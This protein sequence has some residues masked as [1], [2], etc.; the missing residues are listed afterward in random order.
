MKFVISKAFLGLILVVIGI[1]LLL[2]SKG[3]IEG[4]EVFWI[5]ICGVGALLFLVAFISNRS[6]WWFIIPG[7]SLLGITLSM[8]L[9][10]FT[11]TS[12]AITGAVLIGS[13]GLSFFLVYFVQ[14]LHWWA[15]IPGCVLVTLGI[16][17][18]LESSA[19]ENITGGIFFIGLGLT[20]ALVALLPNPV[21]KMTWAWIPAAVL[22]TIAIIT[23]AG[24]GTVINYIWPVVIVLLG[25]YFLWRAFRPG[26]SEH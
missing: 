17:A 20:F 5:I 1:V 13:I 6:A 10:E 23:L 3:W 11:S 24:A 22:L 26:P 19:S 9:S 7:V 25:T 15:I 2:Q 18:A 8:V 21:G 4:S 16:V 14:K 12:D